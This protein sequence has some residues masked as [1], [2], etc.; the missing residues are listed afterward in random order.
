LNTTNSPENITKE[1][2]CQT[3]IG[4]VKKV[5]ADVMNKTNMWMMTLSDWGISMNK[6]NVSGQ[7]NKTQ[8]NITDG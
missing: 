5:H 4:R 2:I 1:D 7:K 3:E 6:K 8:Y